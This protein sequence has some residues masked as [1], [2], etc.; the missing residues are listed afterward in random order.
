MLSFSVSLPSVDAVRRFVG[1]TGQSSVDVDLVS[2]QYTVDGKS[3]MG[4]FSLPL[5]HPVLVR[6]FE[7]A[8]PAQAAELAEKL[9]EFRS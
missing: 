9:K 1:I 7:D 4:I 2:G 5:N 6:I 8:H 3:I